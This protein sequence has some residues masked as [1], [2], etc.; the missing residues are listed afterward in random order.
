MA[1]DDV[2]YMHTGVTMPEWLNPRDSLHAIMANGDSVYA[3]AQD[4]TWFCPQ[5]PIKAFKVLRFAMS[6]TRH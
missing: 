3:E 4:F 6:E 5:D 2:F 1:S